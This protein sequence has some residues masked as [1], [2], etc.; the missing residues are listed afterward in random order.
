MSTPTN[1]LSCLSAFWSAST[2]F[3]D[4]SFCIWF[5]RRSTSLLLAFCYW[6]TTVSTL[7]CF[8]RWHRIAICRWSSYCW[9]TIGSAQCLKHYIDAYSSIR[10]SPTWLMGHTTEILFFWLSLWTISHLLTQFWPK[11]TKWLK[12]S[13]WSVH[14]SETWHSRLFCKPILDPSFWS[15]P[16]Q[17]ESCLASRT[18]NNSSRLISSNWPSEHPPHWPIVCINWWTA[19]QCQLPTCWTYFWYSIWARILTPCYFWCCSW[20]LLWDFVFDWSKYLSYNLL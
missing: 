11:S 15:M 4:I 16:K 18:P 5:S 7:W 20:C 9:Q 8:W 6:T 14:Q 3:Q 17:Y 19:Q 13:W 10:W 1:L 2:V 12:V